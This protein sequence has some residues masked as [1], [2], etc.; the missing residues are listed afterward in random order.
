MMMINFYRHLLRSHSNGIFEVTPNPPSVDL[1]G[2][3]PGD[4]V[5]CLQP[6]DLCAKDERFAVLAYDPQ[7]QLLAIASRDA[8]S[9]EIARV[10]ASQFCLERSINR[11]GIYISHQAPR[12]HEPVKFAGRK[13]WSRFRNHF[14]SIDFPITRLRRELFVELKHHLFEIAFQWGYCT[15]ISRFYLA[16]YDGYWFLLQWV[17]TDWIYR[18]DLGGDLSEWFVVAQTPRLARDRKSE[19]ALLLMTFWLF[20]YND[21]A[22]ESENQ[23]WKD[24]GK[25][26]KIVRTGGKKANY[27]HKDSFRNFVLGLEGKTAAEGSRMVEELI[28]AG[29]ISAQGVISDHPDRQE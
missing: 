7:R 1:T 23:P 9:R 27:L 3:E 14:N 15:G 2:A 25:F 4:T 16:S 26:F 11:S 8:P 17:K 28:G 24:I 6:T 29:L 21:Y 5:V 10:G 20:E 12:E 22:Y 13:V 19:T 18:S